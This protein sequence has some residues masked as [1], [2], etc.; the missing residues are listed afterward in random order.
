MFSTLLTATL[1]SAF[2]FQSVLAQDQFTIYTV[3]LNQCDSA[4]ITW[5]QAKA[6]FNLAVVPVGDPCN[7]IL[8]DLGDHDHLSMTW[9]NVTVPAGTKVMLS[10]L[11][12]SDQEAWSGEITVGEGSSACLPGASSDAASST[13]LS[14]V[15]GSAT[16]LT[17]TSSFATASAFESETATIV[18]AA[19]AGT[20]GNAPSGAM[21]SVRLPAAVTVLSSVAAIAAALVF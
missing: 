5:T 12:S 6:P 20:V 7:S 13:G 10:L 19:N 4:H 15:S 9:P 1:L 11:D 2:V 17:L 8:V 3:A 16:T 18:G 21:P 14:T